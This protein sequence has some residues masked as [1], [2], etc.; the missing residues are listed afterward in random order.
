MQQRH[1]AYRK[2]S[3]KSISAPPN[4][5]STAL[6]APFPSAL[7]LHMQNV[8]MILTQMG[9][10]ISKF[11][12]RAFSKA[13]YA[14]FGLVLCDGR[15]WI[16]PICLAEG[17]FHPPQY[18]QLGTWSYPRNFSEFGSIC[19]YRKT[20]S[21]ISELIVSYPF[22]LFPVWHKLTLWWLR[23]LVI[24]STEGYPGSASYDWI[25]SMSAIM[26]T[27]H[28]FNIISKQILII[29]SFIS[30][31]FRNVQSYPPTAARVHCPYESDT[32]HRQKK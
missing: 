8:C 5:A 18:L 19:S 4:H 7:W 30:L 10:G 14:T 6:V 23:L 9:S 24:D 12:T 32:A 20:D 26:F 31:Y 2:T 29:S 16:L 22:P 21:F 25:D 3:C 27:V 17:G 28:I 1:D 11:L 13:K 15:Q